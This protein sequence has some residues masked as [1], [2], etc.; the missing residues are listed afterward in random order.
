[1]VISVKSMKSGNLSCGSGSKVFCLMLIPSNKMW[2]IAEPQVAYNSQRCRASRSLCFC[3]AIHT[4]GLE[5]SADILIWIRV[6]ENHSCY[7]S[8]GTP[9]AEG[10]IFVKD[11]TASSYDRDWQLVLLGISQQR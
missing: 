3:F 1:M 2:A 10:L 11:S 4:G 8:T 7:P 6:I 9:T 5:T